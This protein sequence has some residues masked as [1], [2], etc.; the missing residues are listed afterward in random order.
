[1][2]NGQ[3]YG[4]DL[5]AGAEVSAVLGSSVKHLTV[6]V[7]TAIGWKKQYPSGGFLMWLGMQWSYGYPSHRKMFRRVLGEFGV[8]PMVECSNY[9]IWT[10]LFRHGNRGMVFVINHYSSPQETDLKIADGGQVYF[11][12]SGIKLKPMEIKN[13]RFRLHKGPQKI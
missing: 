9:N 10:S 1:M 4:C 7:G 13:F 11:D 2:I 3:L 5:P 12:Q 8:K 6:P